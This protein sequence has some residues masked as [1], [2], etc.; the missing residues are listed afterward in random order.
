MF[1]CGN[2][3]FLRGGGVRVAELEFDGEREKVS[4]IC[5][6]TDRKILSLMITICHQS[7]SLVVQNVDHWDRFLL[8]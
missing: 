4:I 3:I 7:A 8:S 6:G 1:Y 5:E 2:K